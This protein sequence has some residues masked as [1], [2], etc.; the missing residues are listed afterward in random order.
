MISRCDEEKVVKKSDVWR[1]L[2]V[3]VVSEWGGIGDFEVL[4]V[5]IHRLRPRR[6]GWDWWTEKQPP[7]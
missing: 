4:V 1:V 2:C 5:K 6:D 3:E 7:G